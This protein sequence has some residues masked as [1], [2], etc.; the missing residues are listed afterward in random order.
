MTPRGVFR[1]GFEISLVSPH[2]TAPREPRQC[3][4]LRRRRQINLGRPILGITELHARGI[5]H[6]CVLAKRPR[7]HLH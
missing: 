5:V 6:S 1:T 2:H 4:R 3:L 7:D